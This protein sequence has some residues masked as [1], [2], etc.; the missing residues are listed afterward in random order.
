[1]NK[2]SLGPVLY[3][4]PREALFDF[5]EQMATTDVDIIYLG[6]TVCSKRK[7]LRTSDWLELA[8]KLTDAGKEVVLST[9]SLIEAESELKTLRSLCDNGKFLVEANDMA[10]VQL[11]EGK[12]FITGHSVNVYNNNS[13]DFLAKIGLIRWVLPVELSRDTLA[14]FQANRPDGVETEVF[15]YGRLPLAYSARCFTARAHNLPKDDCQYRCIDYQDGLTLFSQEDKPFL[16]LNG[17]Q[18]QSACTYNLLSVLPDM[19]SLGVDVL[20]IS[21]Q[22]HHT[23]KIIAAFKN[24]LQKPDFISDEMV[25]LQRFMP[26][27]S[28]DG[29]WHGTAGMDEK[30]AIPK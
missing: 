7:S 23:E 19:T 6:E 5:Y 28:C 1:M 26:V 2:L 10:A 30:V 29:Y 15:V 24:C 16:T 22:S 8:S 4:W 27:G 17:I 13:L 12:K 18:T 9:L 20:R 3:Y 25:K 21:P 11:L 14:D